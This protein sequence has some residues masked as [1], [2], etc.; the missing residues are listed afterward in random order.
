MS[1]SGRAADAADRPG[2]PRL[3][4]YDPARADE[5]VALWNASAGARYPLQPAVL[6]Q[7]TERNPSFSVSDARLAVE[8][9]RVVGFAYLGRHR[10]E[11]AGRR[12]W[13][14]RGWLQA[15]VVA[16]DRRRRGVGRALVDSLLRGARA[17]G[18][19]QVELG[20]GIHY[21]FPGVPADLPDAAPFVAALGAVPEDGTWSAPVAGEE[22]SALAA[23]RTGLSW[24]VR[25][26][27]DTSPAGPAD[28][29]ALEREGLVLGP[30]TASERDE[31]LAYLSA[32]F[33][34]DW[35]HDMAWFLD[36]GGDPAAILLLRRGPGGPVVGHARIVVPDGGPVPPQHYWRDLL[37]PDPGGLG[38][39]GIAPEL[40]G[41]G[42]GRALLALALEEL[43][44]RGG[45]DVVIDWTVLLDYY[46]RFGFRPWKTYLAGAFP[47]PAAA[48][49]SQ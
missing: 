6:R 9:D 37:G 44:R 15:V 40:R 28:R 17:D 7:V 30:M 18:I 42:I 31:M 43:Q 25:G 12:P 29:T 3:A 46:G 27:L 41:R 48:E 23:G 47:D 32:T 36:E 5:V 16:P 34:P 20:G 49:G 35:P 1:P 38:P 33:G 13:A 45:R 39:I 19:G 10:G 14:G 2:P 26:R 4:A 21:L 11:V 24:D 8:D 22:A